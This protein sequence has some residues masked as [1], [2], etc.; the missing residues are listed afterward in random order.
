ME[1]YYLATIL[2]IA[3]TSASM[4]QSYQS[5]NNNHSHDGIFINLSLGYASDETIIENYYG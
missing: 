4:A 1:K 5:T 2:L 3:L